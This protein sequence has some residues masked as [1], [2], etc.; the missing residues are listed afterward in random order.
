MKRMLKGKKKLSDNDEMNNNEDD[1]NFA[2]ESEKPN[3]GE[4]ISGVMIG[5]TNSK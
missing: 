5:D 4:L 3:E 1:Y 2:K